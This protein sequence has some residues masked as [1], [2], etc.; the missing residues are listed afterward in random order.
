MQNELLG[1]NIQG[2]FPLLFHS[3]N[4]FLGL[5][6]PGEQKKPLSALLTES[7][8]FR[9]EQ[10]NPE[11]LSTGGEQWGCVGEE[12]HPCH[13]ETLMGSH[14]AESP[15]PGVRSALCQRAHPSRHVCCNWGQTHQTGRARQGLLGWV[16]SAQSRAGPAGPRGRGTE[17][18]V[19][20]WEI[21]DTDEPEA[22]EAVNAISARAANQ[23]VA[24]RGKQGDSTL[25][26]TSISKD[27]H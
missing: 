5:E 25:L 11:S 2:A 3:V 21:P 27:G 23:A 10:S 24:V 17:P 16:T 14:S 9:K 13:Q 22:L 12:S 1:L 18:S 4:H 8:E 20:C 6:T 19:S 15:A 7:S 26:A